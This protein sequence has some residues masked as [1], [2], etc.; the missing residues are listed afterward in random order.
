[1]IMRYLIYTLASLMVI[2]QLAACNSGGLGADEAARVDSIKA[3]P[4]VDYIGGHATFSL[5]EIEGL[6]RTN[7]DS[8]PWAS[9]MQESDSNGQ[10]GYYFFPG[11]KVELSAPQIRLEYMHKGLKGCGDVDSIF[12]WL[13]GLYVNDAR[14]GKV[15]SEE[16]VGTIDGQPIKVLEIETPM[17]KPNDSL[18]YSSKWMAW[19]YADNGD[20]FIGFSYSA[21]TIDDYKQGIPLFKDL[22]RSYKDDQK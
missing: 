2:V 19:A 14:K 13:K 12:A 7:K 10:L 11:Y 6:R 3:L 17:F 4:R 5:A 18:Q 8:V 15:N 22:V 21:V 1:M 9:F 20:R 16:P